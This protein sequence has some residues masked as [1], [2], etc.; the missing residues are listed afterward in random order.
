MTSWS[1][2]RRYSRSTALV[3]RRTCSCWTPTDDRL[4]KTRRFLCVGD[5]RRCVKASRL[6]CP[7]GRAVVAGYLDPDYRCPGLVEP[8]GRRALRT[9]CQR[10]GGTTHPAGGDRKSVV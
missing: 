5:K 8:A 3:E 6:A 1:I 9:S 7:S 4:V 10:A 2:A